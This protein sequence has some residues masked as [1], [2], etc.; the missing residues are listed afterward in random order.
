MCKISKITLLFFICCALLLTYCG[1]PFGRTNDKNIDLKGTWRF[2]IDE[3]DAGL[4]QKWYNENLDDEITLP[5]SMTTN[6]KGNDVDVNTPWTGSIFDSSYFTDDAYAPYREKGNIKVP[7]WLQ[8]VKYYKGA[9]WY[10]RDIDVPED[11]FDNGAELF[12]ERSHWETMV[13][14]DE[15][16]VGMQNSLA[17]AHRYDLSGILTPGKHRI[18]IRVDNRVK[19]IDVGPNSHSISDHTQ[20]NWNGMI[21]QLYIKPLQQVRISDF[22]L[23]PD[24]EAKQVVVRFEIKNE[25][26]SQDVTLRLQASEK[27]ANTPLDP[28]EQEISLNK[29]EY[30]AEIT[31]PMGDQ[32]A[33]WNEFNPV[34]YQMQAA[35]IVDDQTEIKETKTFG[36]R[37]FSTK[38]NQLLLNG[39]P[40]F[41][42]GTLESAIFPKTGYPPT[43]QAEWAHIFSVCKAYGLNHIR[44]HSWCPPEAAFDAADSL[45]VYLQVEASSWAN[46]GSGLGDGKPIDQF[47]YDES[48]RMVKAYG[49][50]PSFALMAYGNEP[51]GKNHIQ[52]LTKFVEHWKAKDNRR[53]YTAGAGWPAIPEND[54]NNIPEPRI[55]GWGEGLNSIINKERPRTDFD[56]RDD[57]KQYT[58]PTIS[59][60]IG[61]WCVYPDF[62][63]IEKYTGVLKAK[64]FEIFQE[65][66]QENGMGDLADQFLMASGKLQALCYKADIEAALRTPNFGGFQ[67][68]D[69]HDFPGQGTA[70]VGVLNPFWQ[71]KGYTD[72]QSF[73]QFTNSTVALARFPKMVYHNNEK[74]N[75]PLEAA[76]FGNVPITNVTPSWEILG[77]DGKVY[78]SGKLQSTTVPLGNNHPLGHVEVDLASFK[79]P[80]KLSLKVNVNEF[81][82]Q[83]DF[84]VYPK[85][86]PELKNEVIVTQKLDQ[87]ASSLLEQG[88]SVLLTLKKGT[89][90]NEKGGDIAI[91]FSS[92]FWNTAWTRKQAPVTLGILCDPKH[93]ALADF[94]TEY[95]SNWQWWDAMSHSNALKLDEINERLSP[96]V[97]VIDDWVTA[98]PLGLL[99]ECKVGKGKLLVSGIDL[100]TDVESRPEAQQLLYSLKK[101][102]ETDQFNP[103]ED[104]DESIVSGLI[105]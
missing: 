62:K 1:N 26:N 101:Y 32:P 44:F 89:L 34:V 53:L 99:F 81:N 41:F 97:R 16:E 47:I 5:G 8:P 38:G 2:A 48:E 86:L 94:P 12:L 11:I 17:T 64:N 20:S 55:Q 18:T 27:G 9:A 90:K 95:H 43:D 69:L 10:Q 36:M 85:Q 104:V 80:I 58:I 50:H 102:M 100:V 63:E 24:V 31:Y 39:K 6:N 70:L 29:G 92:I 87:K 78:A 84:F 33:L 52:F 105:N 46:Q 77:S 98:R 3:Q 14:I 91:G 68:L 13:W 15:Q 75:I 79:A 88:K 19:E 83:W 49:N 82:N 59:H 66:L 60:E 61:Q 54:Y 96:I 35:V 23:F 73:S 74:L 4:T 37:E 42:R 22:Q 93:P 25:G 65:K 72:A 28:I 21:G 40:V 71:D 45:G 51:G 67:L 57:I 30:T 103:S 56:W 76:H 7:F